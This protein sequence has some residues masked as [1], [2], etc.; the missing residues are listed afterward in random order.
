[1]I[2]QAAAEDANADPGAAEFGYTMAEAS[3][4]RQNN[5]K[6]RDR[7]PRGPDAPMI[8]KGQKWR[9]GSQRFSSR[10]GKNKEWYAAQPPEFFRNQRGAGSSTSSSSHAG[11]KGKSKEQGGTK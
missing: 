10:G 7:G 2:R 4:A 1:M 3:M 6:W 5:I 8:F 9:E 11:G